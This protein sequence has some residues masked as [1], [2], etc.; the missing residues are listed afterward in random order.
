MDDDLDDSIQERYMEP[1]NEICAPVKLVYNTEDSD[2]HV[3][4]EAEREQFKRALDTVQDRFNIDFHQYDTDL[5]HDQAL[6]GMGEVKGST[7]YEMELEEFVEGTE[8]GMGKTRGAN[9][10]PETGPDPEKYR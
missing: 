10:L 8:L 3:L 9:V 2:G 1:A 6:L 7:A 5:G 4:D